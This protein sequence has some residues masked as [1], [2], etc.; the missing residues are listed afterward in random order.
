MAFVE[1]AK[2]VAYFELRPDTQVADFGAGT[3]AY[4]L[5]MSRAVLPN[6]KVYAIDVQKELL[7]TLKNAIQ[8]E[9]IGNIELLWGDIETLG[10]TK[11][12]DQMIDFVLISNVLFQTKAGYQIALEAKRVLKVGGRVGVIDWTESF[13]NM[14]PTPDM[15][16]TADEAKK[17]FESAGFQWE[18]DFPAGDNHYGLIFKKR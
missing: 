13:G 16:V 12:G 5:L 8:T 18:K 2:V 1:P 15:V 6:G 9:H 14:G 17:I 3:G 4:A 11:L 10:G 7:I